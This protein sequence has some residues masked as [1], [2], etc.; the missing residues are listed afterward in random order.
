M[1]RSYRHFACLCIVAT[2]CGASC[3][4][5]LKGRPAPDEDI[6]FPLGLAA[7]PTSPNIVYVVSTDWNQKYNTGWLSTLDLTSAVT[8]GVTD[9][10]DPSVQVE[11]V[12]VPARSAAS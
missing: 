11:R 5:E 7:N 3:R 12:N 4:R 2:L 1:F 10:S 6:Y 8:A 9:I